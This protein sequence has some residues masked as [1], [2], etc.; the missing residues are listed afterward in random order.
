MPSTIGANYV[1][2]SAEEVLEPGQ[3]LG[4]LYRRNMTQPYVLQ[5]L[6]GRV[7]WVQSFHYGTVFYVGD[8]G[9]LIF[10]TLEGVYENIAAAVASVTDKPITGAISRTITP[11]TSGTSRSTSPPPTRP[12]ARSASSA[13]RR[14][15]GRWS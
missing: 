12:E 2:P 10:D 3:K 7:Y 5:R 15:A 11:T 13:A 9:V 14:A 4:D 1:E 8:H 6:A